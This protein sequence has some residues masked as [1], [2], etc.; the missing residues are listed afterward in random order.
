MYWLIPSLPNL[1]FPIPE[2]P[3][4]TGKLRLLL[5]ESNVT[6]LGGGMWKVEETF[7]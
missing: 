6:E 7:D 4:A 2:T 5:I 3:R 1:L